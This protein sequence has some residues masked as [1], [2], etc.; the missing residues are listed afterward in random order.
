MAFLDQIQLYREKL[1]TIWA[2]LDNRRR[3]IFGG[4]AT[5]IF[6]LVFSLVF[7]TAGEGGMVPIQSPVKDLAAARSE[8][9]RY[10]IDSEFSKDRSDLMVPRDKR[11]RAQ[12]ILNAARLLPDGLESYS[13]LGET[14]FTSTEPQRFERVRTHIEDLLRLTIQSMDGIRAASVRITPSSRQ[15][16]FTPGANRNKASVTV[17]LVGQPRLSADQVMSI[18]NMVS[19]SYPQ[20]APEDVFVADTSGHPYRYRGDAQTLSDRLDVRRRLEAATEE[21]ASRTLADYDAICSA[22]I[23]VRVFDEVKSTDLNYQPDGE[24]PITAL[25]GREMLLDDVAPAVAHAEDLELTEVMGGGLGSVYYQNGRPAAG[26]G[27]VEVGVPELVDDAVKFLSGDAL[28]DP[29]HVAHFLSPVSV[30]I[31]T[32]RVTSLE[33]LRNPP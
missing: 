25:R 17:D 24:E 19:A 29:G 7:L 11:D 27:E 21:K 20:L 22:T 8:L 18:T 14:D 15:V 32:Y 31:P 10:G 9:I 33:L 28:R 16:L 3:W 13:F 5:G 1:T 6:A 30:A 26:Q 12:I 2:G 4:A 23:D